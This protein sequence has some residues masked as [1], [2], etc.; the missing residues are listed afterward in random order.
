MST[1]RT[2]VYAWLQLDCRKVLQ[3]SFLQMECRTEFGVIESIGKATF[4]KLFDNFS[5]SYSRY[6]RYEFGFGKPIFQQHFGMHLFIPGHMTRIWCRRGKKWWNRK[7]LLIQLC[8]SRSELEENIY[9][10][11]VGRGH[12]E[13][14]FFFWMLTKQRNESLSK[15]FVKDLLH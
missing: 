14:E 15:R 7:S 3:F 4:C 9:C 8:F 5:L 13:R 6:F 2:K 11:G 1:Q 12:W 10:W